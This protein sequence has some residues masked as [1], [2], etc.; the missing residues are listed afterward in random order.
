MRRALLVL[1]V[2]LTPAAIAAPAH[3]APPTRCSGAVVV[4]SDTAAMEATAIRVRG[5]SCGRGKAVVRAFLMLVRDEP[6]CLHD[7]QFGRGCEWRDHLCLRAN[8]GVPRSNRC[9]ADGTAV[10]WIERDGA[11][12]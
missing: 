1:L 5:Q 9:V 4:G 11:V 2:V 3:A 7:A 6:S 12:I 8:I 10:Y